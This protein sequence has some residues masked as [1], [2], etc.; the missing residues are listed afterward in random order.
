MSLRGRLRCRPDNVTGISTRDYPTPAVRPL[1]S[2]L[3]TNRICTDFSLALPHWSIPLDHM[4]GE[5]LA[6]T[7]TEK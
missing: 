7:P 6:E 3:D 4:L 5:L 1:N 2:R